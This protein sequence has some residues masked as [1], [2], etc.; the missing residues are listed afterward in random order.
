MTKQ[1]DVDE[2]V[3]SCCLPLVIRYRDG[4]AEWVDVKTVTEGAMV[5]VVGS[6]NSVD[7]VIR[8]A[9]DEIREGTPITTASKQSSVSSSIEWK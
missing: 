9:T 4:K 2:S 8:R 5:E 3:G 1:V 6:L 7:I